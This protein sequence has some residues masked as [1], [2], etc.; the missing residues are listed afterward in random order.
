MQSME[1]TCSLLNEKPSARQVLRVTGSSVLHSSRC[2]NPSARATSSIACTLLRMRLLAACA[3]NACEQD[4]QVLQQQPRASRR[5]RPKPRLRR[6]SCV[7]KKGTSRKRTPARMVAAQT[8]LPLGISSGS[9]LRGAPSTLQR[10]GASSSYAPGGGHPG[11][12]RGNSTMTRKPPKS[13]A[14]A[15]GELV[16]KQSGRAALVCTAPQELEAGSHQL[17]VGAGLLSGHR[18]VQILM[19]GGRPRSIHQRGHLPA[20]R[21]GLRQVQPEFPT[22]VAFALTTTPAAI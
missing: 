7:A 11:L 14:P 17:L 4:T 21:R 1:A 2:G 22:L 20:R 15:S 6:V 3:T 12:K 19:Y 13:C 5:A 18:P 10:L 16:P 8:G 9:G